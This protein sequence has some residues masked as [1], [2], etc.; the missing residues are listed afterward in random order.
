MFSS[1]TSQVA[2]GAANY[3][4]D[5]FSTWLYTAIATNQTIT[6]GIDLAG[7]GGL[8]WLKSRSDVTSHFLTDTARGAN[9]ELRTNTAAAQGNFGGVTSFLSNG[10]VADAI[11]PVGNSTV[12]WT[13]RE[14]PKFFDIVTW[15]GNGVAGRQISHELGSVPGCIFVKR[16]NGDASDWYVYHRGLN[17]GVNAAQYYAILNST[18]AQGQYEIWGNTNPTSTVFTVDSFSGVNGSGDTYVAYL[19]A[20]N[21]G[22]FGL[23][24]TDNVISCGSYTGNGSYP[25]GPIID[26]GFEPQWVMVKRATGGTGKWLMLDTMRGWTAN[27]GNQKGLY[28]NTTEREVENGSGL[29]L[30]TRGWQLRDT[31]PEIN[32]N[33]STYI[34]I[35]IRRGPM[36]VPTTGTSVLGLSARAGTSTDVAV[37][38]SAGVTDLSITKIRTS[39][40]EWVWCPRLTGNGYLSSDD[41]RAEVTNSAQFQTNPWDVMSGVKFGTGVRTNSNS[42]TY[43]NYFLDRAPNFMDAV[44]YT[45]TG[46]T[47]TVAHNLTVAPE[48]II[49]KCRSNADNWPTYAAPLGATNMTWFNLDFA[50]NSGVTNWWNNTAPT[51]SVFTVRSDSSVNSSGQTYVAYLFATCPG[52]SSVGSYTG[53]GSSQTINCGFTSGARFVMVKR[54]NSTGNWLVV[55]TARGLVSAGDPTMYFNSTSADVNAIDWVDPASSGFIVNQEGTMNA[56]VNGGAYIYLAIA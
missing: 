51:A 20:H 34:Y 19:F 55:D 53:N 25:N 18:A 45:G 21:A 1:N 33:G 7:K 24:G 4:E 46:N 36:K 43:I 37:S 54:T 48:L 16:L 3:I 32:G 28:A 29:E 2:D 39:N 26:V 14:Q 22:G 40:Q 44:C 6:N 5:V 9:F 31:D 8:V 30:Q 27:L 56:N 49:I 50:T 38:S 23:T 15:T 52:V 17:N 13:F 42:A 10:F 35:A 41:T 47:R 12:S 11:G